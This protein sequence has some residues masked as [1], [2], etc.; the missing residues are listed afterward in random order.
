[1][2]ETAQKLTNSGCSLLLMEPQPPDA[3]VAGVRWELIKEAASQFDPDGVDWSGDPVGV[4]IVVS[5][6]HAARGNGMGLSHDPEAVGAVVG[7]P[8]PGGRPARLAVV[9]A[10]PPFLEPELKRLELFAQ[11]AAPYVAPMMM[12]RIGA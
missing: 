6:M 12:G 4:K 11:V 8:V 5:A 10:R 7:I 1:V 3:R 2:A 9:G